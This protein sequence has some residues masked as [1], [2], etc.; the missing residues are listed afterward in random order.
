MDILRVKQ[1]IYVDVISKLSILIESTIVL[2]DALSYSK[3]KK[4]PHNLVYYDFKLVYSIIKK[5]RKKNPPYNFRKILGLYYLP[6]NTILTKQEKELVGKIYS[7]IE[8]VMITKVKSIIEFYDNF[9]IVY[10]KSKHGLTMYSGIVEKNNTKF[11]FDKSLLRCYDRKNKD[12]IPK[13][14]IDLKPN[15][16]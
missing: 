3:Y 4:I 15:N 16:V 9:R 5:L 2:L 7:K 6:K 8:K 10:G 13:N 1:N 14:H 12:K 11:E